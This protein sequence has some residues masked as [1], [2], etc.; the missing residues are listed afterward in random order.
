MLAYF[1]TT[2]GWFDLVK[3]TARDAVR[4]DVV[5]LAAQLA[6][7]FVLA[8]FPALLCLIAFA[9]LFPLHALTDDMA[10]LLGPIAP[11]AA[12]AIIQDEMVKLAA[13]DDSGLFS[14]GLLGALWSSSAAM[15]AIVNA[16]NRAYDIVE[17]RPWWRVRLVAVLLTL[18]LAFFILIALTLV[19]A[20]P[21]LA[22]WCAQWMGFPVVFAWIWKILQWP[23]V[24]AL[25]ATGI[26]LIYYFAPDAEQDWVWITP[27]SLI[28]TLLWL[29]G[30]LGFRMYVVHV[31]NYEGTY[32][33]IAGVIV[34]MVWFYLTGLAIVIGAEL[35]AE[36][37]KASP[38]ARPA[39]DS[40]PGAKRR[41]GAAA[42]RAYHRRGAPGGRPVASIHG[43][44]TTLVQPSVLSRNIR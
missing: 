3:R 6:Y 18:G 28:A 38:W 35:N 7:Y 39:G 25:A 15:G 1:G 40:R 21:E 43:R 12:I 42:E 4:D 44:I 27:G 11:A 16:V 14:L 30:S 23:L 2:I 13:R 26:G 5:G 10:R 22:D 20:G 36:I 41:L 37:E 24:C 33:A 29:A 34:V 32:G 8:L 31:S 9:S 19:L 17:A